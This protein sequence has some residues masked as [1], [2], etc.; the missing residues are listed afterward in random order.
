LGSRDF[1][2]MALDGPTGRTDCGRLSHEVRAIRRGR[3]LVADGEAL[4]VREVGNAREAEVGTHESC[5]FRH[6]A[7]LVDDAS[8]GSGEQRVTER[9]RDRE[10]RLGLAKTAQRCLVAPRSKVPVD[11]LELPERVFERVSIRIDGHS[12]GLPGHTMDDSRSS[13]PPAISIDPTK[14]A[15]S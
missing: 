5:P 4:D 13:A 7:E 8:L 14:I 9:R 2:A 1:G 10:A 12:P 6:P 3:A 11:Q 15:G